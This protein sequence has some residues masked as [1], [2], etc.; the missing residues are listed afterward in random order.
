M[1]KRPHPTVQVRDIIEAMKNLTQQERSEMFS[2]FGP[3]RPQE[4]QS[5]DANP[6]MAAASQCRVS[7]FSGDDVKG[8]V[9]YQQWRHEVTS[10]VSEGYP[11]NMVMLA[12]R[13]LLRGTANEVMLNL[14]PG[15]TVRTLLLKFDTIFGIV[16]TA[17]ALLEDVYRAKQKETE[18]TLWC[19]DVE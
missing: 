12:I 5:F 4:R 14:G 7:F 15:I 10:L 3:E 17:E 13:R 1:V 6:V 16:L 2:L 9:A 11:G 19:G 18:K 8:V